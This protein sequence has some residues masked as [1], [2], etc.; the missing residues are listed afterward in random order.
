[1]YPLLISNGLQFTSQKPFDFMMASNARE[2]VKTVDK[3][4]FVQIIRFDKG[5]H[6]T[7]ICQCMHIQ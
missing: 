2:K 5:K 3:T 4:H 7:R 6:N 1:M